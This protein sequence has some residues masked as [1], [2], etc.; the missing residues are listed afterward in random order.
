MVGGPAHQRGVRRETGYSRGVQLVLDAFN[1]L[2]IT[3]VLP[4]ELAGMDLDGLADLIEATRFAKN[5]A[6]IVCDGSRQANPPR[7]R[8]RVWF[9]WAGGG[10]KADDV[11]VGLVQRSSSP[12]RMTIVTSDRAI[13]KQ[14]RRRGADVMT[15]EEFLERLV[16]DW[17]HT[18]PAQRT[19]RLPGL[20]ATVPLVAA[21]VSHWLAVFGIGPELAEL[22]SSK[23]AKAERPRPVTAP[24]ATAVP[25][26]EPES[27]K[28]D[29]PLSFAGIDLGRLLEG[30]PPSRDEHRSSRRLRR[31]RRR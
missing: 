3:G 25:A 27:A 24:P 9:S 7:R 15:S 18:K 16:A 30:T 31:D 13:A 8:E 22:P 4:P 29:D 10:L 28:A 14:V 1:I 5:E 23:A 19:R 26:V 17:R 20:R 21:E 11:I 2:H 6:W 12:R